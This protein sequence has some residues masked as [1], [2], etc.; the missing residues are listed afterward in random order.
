[1]SLRSKILI[2]AAAGAL[3]V[4]GTAAASFANTYSGQT[5]HPAVR[6]NTTSV[7]VGEGSIYGSGNR[8][9]VTTSLPGASETATHY[10]RVGVKKFEKGNLER[11]EQAFNA[12]LRADGLNEQAHFYLAK[13]KMQQGDRTAAAKHAAKLGAHTEL[14]K[15]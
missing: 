1:M 4:A 7:F 11:A 5:T 12:V 15:K 6:Y 10:Y 9:G 13:I 2:P 8:F 3:L 14:Y